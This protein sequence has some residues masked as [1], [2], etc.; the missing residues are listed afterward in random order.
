VIESHQFKKQLQEDSTSV[1]HGYVNYGFE[2][3][4]SIRVRPQK[5]SQSTR[6]KN[7]NITF[8]FE[9]SAM[10]ICGGEN[11][12]FSISFFFPAAVFA[13][14][15]FLFLYFRAFQSTATKSIFQR[16][17]TLFHHPTHG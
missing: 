4:T 12:Y 17:E 7:N 9:S 8:D 13:I 11:E 5:C 6:I 10:R 14:K 3:D 2:H 15:K 1:S 16:N